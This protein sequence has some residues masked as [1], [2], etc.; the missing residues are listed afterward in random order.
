MVTPSYLLMVDGW[1]PW[2]VFGRAGLPVVLNPDPNVGGELAIGGAYLLTAGLG[3][4]AELIG[5]VFYGAATWDKKI[6]TI[7]MLSVQ[8]GII[9]D[10]EVLP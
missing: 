2:L 4:Q 5:N 7:P 6:T 3:L 10:Y 1:R 8:A 9:V